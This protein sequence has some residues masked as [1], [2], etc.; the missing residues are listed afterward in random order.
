MNKD[1]TE[2]L[3]EDYN[4]A[5]LY[6]L[7][8]NTASYVDGLKNAAR[9]TVFV[10]R[11]EHLGETPIKV[12][13]L[14]SKVVD[15]AAYLHGDSGIQTTIVTMNQAYC[16]KNNL[17]VLEAVGNF[18]TRFIPEASAARYI[19]T[20]PMKYFDAI[21]KKEDDINLEG[22]EFE[23]QAIEPVFYV[24]TLPMILVNGTEGIGVGF[25]SKIHP[26][27][28]Q[29]MINAVRNTIE[30][31]RL[32]NEWFNPYWNGFT[33]T[34]E[35][36]DGTWL[37]K[38]V[39][40]INGKKVEITELPM[41]E[42]LASYLKNLRKLKEK[43]VIQKFNDYSEDD[44]FH[45]EV[46]LSDDEAAKD[47]DQ[48]MYDLGL[49]SKM[50]ETLTC[51]DENNK[52]REYNNVREIF[53]DYY[54]IKIKYLKLRIKSELARLANEEKIV[55]ESYRFVKEV[56]DNT[57]NIRAKKSEVEKE[58]K[59][60]GYTII[61]KLLSMPVSSLTSDKMA[62]LKKKW[63]NVKAEI[64]AMKKETPESMWTKDL[65]TL[66]AILELEGRL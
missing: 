23:G 12:S 52:V 35:E 59:Q 63:N 17:P 24:P 10:T 34:V 32:K 4:D 26:R 64:S 53:N 45:F 8:R 11:K 2:Y 15:K 31:K 58:L 20:R 61:E 57:V 60:K 54:K 46:W 13:A 30:G 47:D 50:G 14:G 39:C 49:V 36:V 55:S 51:F 21:Y 16:G 18:G 19:F 37:V 27:S 28:I 38:G 41:T 65:D 7:F 29:G 1:V 43:K 9:K 40:Q 6:M 3:N 44:K 48:I 25:S 66:E 5:A 56:V 42:D 33:G 22:Q 62:E